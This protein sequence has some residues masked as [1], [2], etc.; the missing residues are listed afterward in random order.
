MS[1][2]VEVGTPIISDDS[3][4]AV[5]IPR[6]KKR[7]E[8]ERVKERFH[9]AFAGGFSAGY[10]NTVGSKEGWAPKEF[11]SF[12]ADKAVRASF[13]RLED[14]MDEEDLADLEESIELVSVNR[15]KPQDKDALS[16]LFKSRR[17][18]VGY[19]ILSR[20]GWKEGQGVGP[21]VAKRLDAGG[22]TMTFQLAPKESEHQ[23]HNVQFNE[24]THGLGY[25][26]KLEAL[27]DEQPVPDN[28]LKRKQGE[29][30]KNN[31][32]NNHRKK[33][34]AM[35]LSIAADYEEDE[36]EAVVF[37]KP[38]T[39]I[40][41]RHRFVA[42]RQS[43]GINKKLSDGQLPIE[44]FVVSTI[45]LY[46]S[47]IFPPLE[48]PDDFQIYYDYDEGQYNIPEHVDKKLSSKQRG[49]MLHEK[50]LPAKSIFE[51][52]TN[53]ERERIAR[54]L[55]KGSATAEP[56]PEVTAKDEDGKLDIDEKGILLDVEIP[57]ISESL[58]LDALNSKS[59]PYGDNLTKQHR[60]LQYLQ[61]QATQQS[62]DSLYQFGKQ[63]G[64]DEWIR[65]LYEFVN[66]AKI[67]KP[68]KGA[69]AEK[70]TSSKNDSPPIQKETPREEA[71]R[72]SNYGPLT[73]IVSSFVPERLLCKR[74]GVKYVGIESTSETVNPDVYL[75]TIMNSINKASEE[76]KS[77]NASKATPEAPKESEKPTE[78][79]GNN[80]LLE[81]EK[82]SM[83]LLKMVFGDDDDDEEQ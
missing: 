22:T 64:A 8:Q 19:K 75:A 67:F 3:N 34:I 59:L 18:S 36:E 25:G 57:A 58:A 21:T 73:R 77:E 47:K 74:F 54:I 51:L 9:G 50:R 70:F 5:A 60:Y 62:A 61:V 38:R 41:S 48:V 43:T 4:S 35:N 52:M 39:I 53:N 79:S 42:P 32:S 37:E 78:V 80:D 15:A 14:Y 44:G 27:S 63:L 30:V 45:V 76:I 31:N 72:L 83:D 33:R 46:Q 28:Q 2:Y 71:A 65:E 11:K 10:F 66:V 16:K 56:E 82:A 69:F 20:M 13:N 26:F 12:R 17:D 7:D 23:R 49:D 24:A 40:Q 68:L 6:W 55:D 81:S 29:N 1:S